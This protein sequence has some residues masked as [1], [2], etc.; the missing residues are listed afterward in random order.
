MKLKWIELNGF[1]SFPERTKIEI[2]EG[3]TCFIGPNGTGKS[4]IVDAFRWIL[5]EHNPRILRGEKMED[6]IFQGSSSKK[7]RGLAE[8]SIFLEIEKKDSND[9]KE[10]ENIEI[11]RRLYK[12]GDSE[13]LINGRQ[14]RLKDLKEVFVSQGVD[15]KN[16]AIIDQIKL[17]EILFRA[18]QR[19]LLLEECA[20]VSFYKLKRTEAEAKLISAKENLQRLEDII[21][22]VRKQYLL[23]EKQAK[24]A[25]RYRKILQELK[26]LELK[27]AKKEATSFFEEIQSLKVEI[28]QIR[29]RQDY[30]GIQKN[31]VVEEI[32]KIKKQ[33]EEKEE[34]LKKIEEKQKKLET[35]KVDLEKKLIFLTQERK[36]KEEIIER[37]KDENI[38]IDEEIKKIEQS[39]EIIKAE[40]IE[41]ENLINPL[42]SE[43]TL[44]EKD[45][46]ASKKQQQV[47]DSEIEREKKNLFNLSAELSNKKNLRLNLEKAIESSEY[48]LKITEEKIKEMNQKLRYLQSLKEKEEQTIQKL[49][50]LLNSLTLEEKKLKEELVKINN[51]LE[52]TSQTMIEKKKQEAIIKNKTETLLSEV[53]EDSKDKVIFLDLLEV[54]SE[55]EEALENFLEDKLKAVVVE[56]IEEIDRNS[57]QNFYFLRN[58]KAEIKISPEESVPTLSKFIKIKE[59]TIPNIFENVIVVE[60]INKAIELKDRYKGYTFITNRGEVIYP[61]G[62]IKLKKS[63]DV[64]RKKKELERLK[65]EKNKITE[66]LNFIGEKLKELKDKK[67]NLET[68]LETCRGEIYKINKE[69]VQKKESYK[70]LCNETE[71]TNQKVGYLYKEEKAL[72]QEKQQ[73]FDTRQKISADID[74]LSEM[75]KLTEDKIERLKQKAFNISKINIEKSELISD[76]KLKLITSKEKIKTINLQ[77]EKINEQIKKLFEKKERNLKEITQNK[78]KSEYLKGE[79]LEIEKRIE[80]LKKQIFLSSE[81]IEN[82]K[83]CLAKEKDNLS[84]L[85]EDY[86]KLTEEIQ[87]NTSNF[88]KK[89]VELKELT[90]KLESLWNE[91]YNFYGVDILKEKIEPTENTEAFKLKAN[92]LKAQ[93]KEIGPV[94][95]EI[96]KEFEEI[97]ERYY[98]LIEQ[99]KDLLTSIKEI[100]EA[101]RKI[102]NISKKK[103]KETFNLLREKYSL[104]FNELF[105]GGKAD[106]LL[107]N[108]NNILESEIDIYVQLPGKKS[109]NI[110]LFSGG[111]KT[112]AAL[113]LIFACLSVKPSPICIFDEVDATLDDTNTI[114]L[115]KLLKEFSKHIQFLII[116]H[117]KLMIEIADYVYGVTMQEEGVSSVISIKLN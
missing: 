83:D 35:E 89:E 20:G 102:N 103:L 27:V 78:A 33:I 41:L 34:T 109:N 70:N 31:K 47:I 117:N 90:I 81:E 92:Q 5:G 62:F 44:Y 68:K 93:L 104:I 94:D 26:N 9:S 16:Y 12:I 4:N 1:K 51:L 56:S 66:E 111:E 67:Q 75:I 50:N 77:I 96:L 63:R 54:H 101:I 69:L 21:T 23:L 108:E 98:F 80:E 114:K 76:K 113:A 95:V 25:E 88:G 64:F 30:L 36:S 73:N 105:E 60:S 48:R 42:Q 11:K 53:C 57:N 38:E 13:F 107:T 85:E 37:L 99:Q 115:R 100:E 84:K 61:E 28:E 14:V 110:N 29:M 17:N 15:I 72:L 58:Y 52:E 19:K 43:I 49:E 116:T 65:E 45:I 32:Q 10:M 97:R 3:V 2:H 39:L 59:N 91:I 18:N 46:D 82:L 6:I 8:V 22:E 106:L 87:I 86:K 7:E 24:K 112:L 55:L 74:Y 40:K 71:T 79:I